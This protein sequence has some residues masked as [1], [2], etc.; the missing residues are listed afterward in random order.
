MIWERDRDLP[1][2]VDFGVTE[3]DVP[4]SIMESAEYDYLLMGKSTGLG[5]AAK[6]ETLQDQNGKGT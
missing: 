2:I 5:P 1:F 4:I 6:R 3:E